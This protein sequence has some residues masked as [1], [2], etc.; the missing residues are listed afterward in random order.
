MNFEI[1]FGPYGPNN[2]RNSSSKIIMHIDLFI[3]FN[4]YYIC[5]F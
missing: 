5:V 3:F 2:K 4:L 1:K